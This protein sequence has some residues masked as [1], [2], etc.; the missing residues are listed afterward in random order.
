MTVAITTVPGGVNVALV[1]IAGAGEDKDVTN[2]HMRE[3]VR[4]WPHCGC[5]SAMNCMD[6]KNHRG[7][8]WY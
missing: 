5:A 8:D 1:Q 4:R 3:M 6:E 7:L 2:E